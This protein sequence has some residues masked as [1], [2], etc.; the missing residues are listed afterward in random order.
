MHVT[1]HAL[2]LNEAAA[3]EVETTVNWYFVVLKTTPDSA[4]AP[5]APSTGIL[6]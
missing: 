3:D 5:V 4:G 6:Y 2:S 1:A